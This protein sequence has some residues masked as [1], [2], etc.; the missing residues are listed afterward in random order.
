MKW[1][2]SLIGVSPYAIIAFIAAA[3]GLFFYGR[4]E[5][6]RAQRLADSAEQLKTVQ[7]QLTT[8]QFKVAALNETATKL[9]TK[10][11]DIRYVFLVLNKSVDALVANSAFYAGECF[12]ADGV[13]LLN[14]AIAAKAP[15]P[16]QPRPALRVD[17]PAL[18]RNPVNGAP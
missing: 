1:L 7:L 3:T 5:G 17:I 14:A 18:G 8:Y 12:D 13:Q 10:L 9:E 16:G 11:E 2:L 15:D 4:Y 6:G